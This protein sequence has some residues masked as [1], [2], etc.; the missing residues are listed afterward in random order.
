MAKRSI[1]E[2]PPIRTTHVGSL[3]RPAGLLA[4]LYA[5]EHDEDHDA[6]ALEACID[7]AVAGIVAEQ[8]AIGIDIINDGEVG[9]TG[10]A[11]Y[12]Q[13]RLS[14]FSGESPSL[15][16]DDLGDFPD[17]RRRM[18]QAAGTRRLHRPRCTGPIAIRNREPLA[19]E[20]SRLT[21]ASGRRPASRTVS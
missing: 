10:Y 11:T 15:L 20:I 17:Y 21:S 1:S 6:G 5:K 3:P 4:L 19:R 12:V 8:T 14:G 7:R 9:R 18:A 2:R 13:D 16:F